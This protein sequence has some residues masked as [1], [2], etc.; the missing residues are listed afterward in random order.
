M[1]PTDHLPRLGPKSRYMLALAGIRDRAELERLGSVR[2][3]LQVKR[4]GQPASLN[5]LWGLESALT[6]RHWQ[7]VAREDRTRLLLELDALESA[8]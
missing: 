7:W 8:R 1:T 4:T 3:F 5:L 6:G 2:A